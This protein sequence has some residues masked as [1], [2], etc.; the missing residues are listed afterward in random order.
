MRALDKQR[1]L[2]EPV[3]P[4]TSVHQILLRGNTVLHSNTGNTS[5]VLNSPRLAQHSVAF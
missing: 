4:S 5:Q 3:E 2:T 1:A